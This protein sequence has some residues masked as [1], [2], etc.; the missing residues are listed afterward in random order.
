MA[1]TYKLTATPFLF[2]EGQFKGKMRNVTFT[3]QSS[4]QTNRWFATNFGH[5]EKC[6]SDLVG[7]KLAKEI[8]TALRKGEDVE[9]PSLYEKEQFDYGFIYMGRYRRDEGLERQERPE[10]YIVQ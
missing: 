3:A 1:G 7:V 9:F 10:W 4:T 2:C 6:F 8:V 5:F